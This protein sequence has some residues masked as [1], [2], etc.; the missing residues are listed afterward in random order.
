VKPCFIWTF[1]NDSW[2][3]YGW[4]L[5]V[6]TA[7]KRFGINFRGRYEPFAV[8]IMR[9]FPCG[10]LPLWENFEVWMEAF[11]RTYPKVTKKRQKKQGMVLAWAKMKNGE[12]EDIFR[13]KPGA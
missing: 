1:F 11:A 13:E 3:Y 6:I 10:L 5:Y 7:K 8:P 2:I 12:L 9:L 4:W